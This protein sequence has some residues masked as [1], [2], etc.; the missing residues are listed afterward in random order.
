MSTRDNDVERMCAGLRK[1]LAETRHLD[2]RDFIAA[3]G[4]TMAGSALMTAFAGLAPRPAQAAD[5]V[6]VM[7][8]GGR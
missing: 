3:L 8:F 1:L 4:R 7:S 6:T 5:P 2:R